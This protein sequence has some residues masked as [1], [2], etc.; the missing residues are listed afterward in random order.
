[1]KKTVGC[2]RPGDGGSFRGVVGVECGPALAQRAVPAASTIRTMRRLAE[3]AVVLAFGCL[4]AFGIALF[5]PTAAVQIGG[6]QG[7][8]FPS[9]E[10]LVFAPVAFVL[11]LLA[12]HSGAVANETVDGHG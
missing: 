4:V 9:W 3:G 6:A 8:V 2:G 11:C 7:T 1:M 10:V 12:R 5:H